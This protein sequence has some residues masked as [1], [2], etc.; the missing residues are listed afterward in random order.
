M[1]I[2]LGKECA[3]R[4]GSQVHDPIAY[5]AEKYKRPAN[6]MSTPRPVEGSVRRSDLLNSSPG[7][8]P[9]ARPLEKQAG[10]TRD[11]NRKNKPKSVPLDLLSTVK[12]KDL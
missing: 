6:A 10:S 4:N 8:T 1:E 12:T 9:Q 2:G 11:S 5:S 7:Q 3:N